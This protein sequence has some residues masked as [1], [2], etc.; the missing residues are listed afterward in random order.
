[1]RSEPFKLGVTK[2]FSVSTAASSKSRKDYFSYSCWKS[3]PIEVQVT[4][5]PLVSYPRVTVPLD[6]S[7]QRRHWG[8]VKSRPCPLWLTQ[9][10]SACEARTGRPDRRAAART[11]RAWKPLAPAH[12]GPFPRVRRL[13]VLR[14]T[15]GAALPKGTAGAPGSRPRQRR[16]Q[17]GRP[18][19]ARSGPPLR[20]PRCSPPS[21]ADSGPTGS[22]PTLLT[23]LGLGRPCKH[24]TAP[25]GRAPR[26]WGLA[27]ST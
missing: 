15:R 23:S 19:A 8:I 26:N 24:I 14:S 6:R 11:R 13:G 21:C 5:S 27:S 12:G 20:L 22:G 7:L 3:Q 18:E 25:E 4:R 16:W 10:G 17:G 9:A 1:M 2:G